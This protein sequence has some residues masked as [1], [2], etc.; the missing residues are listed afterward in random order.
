MDTVLTA[1]NN[2]LKSYCVRDVDEERECLTNP[3][4]RGYTGT[5]NVAASGKPCLPWTQV[6]TQFS[7]ALPDE[8]TA[9]ALNYC[10]YIP[11]QPWT[12]T[13][14]AVRIIG[15]H[16]QRCN[17]QYCGGNNMLYHVHV[18]VYTY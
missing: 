2:S 15:I 14:C 13:S 6:P 12:G 4:G 7:Y 16:L 17:V 8:S 11:D 3:A 1:K 18:H 10:R 5:V 9:D